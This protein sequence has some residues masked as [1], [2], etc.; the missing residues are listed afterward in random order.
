MLLLGAASVVK[1]F[2]ALAFVAMALSLTD[3]N[4]A[5]RKSRGAARSSGVATALRAL[6]DHLDTLGNPDIQFVAFT[7]LETADAVIANAACVLLAL[8]F[9]KPTASTVNAWLKGSDNTTTAGA[10]GDI[11]FK[12]IGTS[13][14]G[15]EYCPIFADG[16]AFGTGLTLGSHTG[17]QRFSKSLVADAPSGFA[18]IGASI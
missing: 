8:Y 6:R 7:G 3:P 14:G 10:S 1:V 15:R 13:G 18:I 11:V 17:E 9:K 16:L 5:M 4:T 2:C 12:L